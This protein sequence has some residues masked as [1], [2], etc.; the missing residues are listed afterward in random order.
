V[1]VAEQLTEPLAYHGEGAVWYAGWGGLKWVDM[2]DGDVLT[3][4][5]ET[6][7]VDRLNVG[8]PIAALVRPRVAGGFVVVTEREITLW[9]AD[10]K[11]WSTP[12]LWSDAGRRFN[13]GGCDPRGG[14]I[15]GSKARDD[16]PRGG[17]VFRM[18]ADRTVERL[19]G[20][21]TISNGLGFSADGTRMFYVDTPTRR[22]D[23]FDVDGACL[24]NR[25]PFVS[26]AEGAG[27][28]D[29]LWVDELDGVWVALYGGSAV[30]HYGPQGTLE[31]VIKVSATQVTSCTFGGPGLDT[32]FITTS[33]EGLAPGEQPSAGA[34]FCASV[35]VRGLPVLA[36]RG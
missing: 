2:L 23:V 32:L 20:D 26:I 3:L 4:R 14:I 21:V 36:Y 9:E 11:H 7:A 29:G 22:V 34:V 13:E 25:R 35:S 6:G 33:R 28:P 5:L 19:F 12:A 15:C 30:H 10:V 27:Y 16:D 1:S 18:N 17:E 31:D 24:L 8:S